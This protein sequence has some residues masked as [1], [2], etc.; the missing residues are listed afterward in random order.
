M[1]AVGRDTLGTRRTLSVGTRSYEYFSLPATAQTL[2]DIARLPVSLKVLLE[3]LLRFED[4]T[5]CTVADARA[6]AEWLTH[7][8]S[9]KEIPFRPA[10]I[11]MQDSPACRR[12]SISPLCVMAFCAS[13]AIRHR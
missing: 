8:H 2:G 3:N 9:D 11:L 7:A 1:I 12:W 5:A 10:R 4:G 6:I 13:A